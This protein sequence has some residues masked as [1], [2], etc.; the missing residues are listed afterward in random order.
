MTI[1]HQRNI[2]EEIKSRLKMRNACYNSLQNI[3]SSRLLSQIVKI[4]M[5]RTIISC[6]V[7]YGH[8]TW[9][10]IVRN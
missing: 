7:F 2:I 3:L 10:F 6:V 4:K 9:S 8:G 1:T 5:C